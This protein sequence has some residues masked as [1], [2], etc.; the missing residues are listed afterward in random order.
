VEY[1]AD[2]MVDLVDIVVIC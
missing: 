1:R 2:F